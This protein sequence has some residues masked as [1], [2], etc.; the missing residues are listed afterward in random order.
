MRAPSG[1]AAI[2][3][4]LCCCTGSRRDRQFQLPA[5]SR[6]PTWRQAGGAKTNACESSFC[7]F[8][9][10]SDVSIAASSRLRPPG[11]L[12]DPLSDGQLSDAQLVSWT[13]RQ[14]PARAVQQRLRR[15]ERAAAAAEARVDERS[16][17]GAA[18]RPPAMPRELITVSVGQAGNQ[19]GHR[20]WELAVREHAAYNTEG[21]FDDS[22]SRCGCCHQWRWGCCRHHQWQ[23]GCCRQRRQL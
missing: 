8:G 20:F 21:L 6:A 17:A 4:L 12:A 5:C 7:L 23:C 3:C 18:C 2:L 15:A 1:P 14:Q 9:T 13:W 16:G 22:M 10:Q 19:I 11:V